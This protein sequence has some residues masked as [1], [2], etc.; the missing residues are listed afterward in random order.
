MQIKKEVI[1][2]LCVYLRFIITRAREAH[3]FCFSTQQES[4]C[5]FRGQVLK[6]IS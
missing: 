3:S 4:F 1:T 5:V 6:L 2:I